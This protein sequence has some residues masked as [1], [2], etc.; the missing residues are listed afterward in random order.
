MPPFSLDDDAL[1]ALRDILF[2]EAADAH[3]AACRPGVGPNERQLRGH[4]EILHRMAVEL[5]RDMA[6]AP[7]EIDALAHV[8]RSKL[9]DLRVELGDTST[10]EG[11]EELRTQISALRRIL[12]QLTRV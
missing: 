3:V 7:A 12:D 6:L 8:V 10:P 1:D 11:R 4:A 5:D 2:L 9:T